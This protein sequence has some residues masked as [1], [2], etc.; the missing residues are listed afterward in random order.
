MPTVRTTIMTAVL[1]ATATAVVPAATAGAAP[2]GAGAAPRAA[3]AYQ[4]LKLPDG[5]ATVY[6]DGLAEVFRDSGGTEFRWVPLTTS[7]G[8]TSNALPAKGQV[9][10]D[11]ARGPAAKFRQSEVVV[12]YRDGVTASPTTPHT[13][14]AKLNETLAGLGVDR[15]HQLFSD[16]ADLGA[17]RATAERAVG[18]PLL[19]FEHAFVLHLAA[20]SVPAAVATLRASADVEYAAPNWTVTS[21]ATPPTPV[22]AAN[23]QARAQAQAQ[24][25]TAS[26]VPS[27]YVLTTSAQS[28]LN[29]PGV[30]AVS[31]FSAIADRFHQLPGEGETITNVS[32]GDLDDASA[33]ADPNDPCNFY[34]ANYGPTTEVIDGQR[35]IDWPSMPLIPT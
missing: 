4:N 26:G 22:P 34:A 17:Q 20:A 11:L 33:A 27:N 6:S 16:A 15:A 18:H 1:T 7:D 24:A 13:N 28:L 30:N 19:G 12:I 14:Q 5:H 10:A 3:V 35:Y 32:L 2:T 25:V 23:A 8:A 9:L 29:H 21:T 31:A